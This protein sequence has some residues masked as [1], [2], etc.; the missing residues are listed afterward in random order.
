MNTDLDKFMDSLKIQDKPED[1]PT[2]EC[3][4]FT[5]QVFPL[6]KQQEQEGWKSNITSYELD[7][8]YQDGDA[9]QIKV[10]VSIIDYPEMFTV[11]G[12]NHNHF[13]II[14]EDDV[15][16]SEGTLEDTPLVEG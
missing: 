13:Q 5:E 9:W 8:W 3:L 7:Y 12:N 11:L 15:I 10:K 1:M 2:L 4:A 6:T 14:D 16:I